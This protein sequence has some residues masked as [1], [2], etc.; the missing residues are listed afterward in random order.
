MTG[1]KQH[2]ITVIGIFI[3]L[4]MGIFIGSTTSDDIIIR[5]QREVIQDLEQKNNHLH[6]NYV[7]LS[8]ELEE[9]STSMLMA[10]QLVEQ[11]TEWYLQLNPIQQ[12]VML[13]HDG[14]D[15]MPAEL[16]SYLMENVIDVQLLL[17]DVT[18]KAATLVGRAITDGKE[19]YLGPL[20]DNL[21]FEGE[22][23][24]PD[25]VVLVVGPET[26]MQFI[27]E[28][29]G[30]MLDKGMPVVAV[31]KGQRGSLAGLFEHALYSS[32]SHL[33]TPH[34]L[35]SLAAVLHGQSG[36]YGHDSVLFP[37]EAGQ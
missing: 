22:W 23:H 12:K 1:Y 4:A 30:F 37:G 32:V 3:A 18:S 9:F 20:Q 35:Y 25:I 6:E 24:A 28:L 27:T 16:G 13:V 8:Q 33:D 31:G 2:L 21:S 7:S 10:R 26:N 14:K 34:G 19:Y 5:Q 11:L 17:G 15:F 29:G 36:H